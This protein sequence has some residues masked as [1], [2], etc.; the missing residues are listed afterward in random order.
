MTR[1]RKNINDFLDKIHLGDCIDI[2]SEIPDESVDMAFADP[3][4]NLKKNYGNYNDD[5]EDYEY[6]D[7][8]KSWI[9][10]LIRI[11][12]PSGTLFLHNIPKWLIEYGH[13]LNKKNMI[14]KHWIAWDAMSTPLG[15]TLLPNHYGILYY[16]KSENYKFY[17]L[18]KPHD[19]CRVCGE[20]QKDYGGKKVQMHPFGPLL[21]DVWTDIHRI[22]H[23]KRRDDH[24]NQLPEQLLERLILMVTDKGDIVVDPVVGVGTTAIAAKRQGRRFIGID[25]EKTY[26][27]I[28]R[29]KIEDVH[30]DQ[31]NGYFYNYNKKGQQKKSSNLKF[32]ENHTLR[33][34]DIIVEK[35]D[36]E[37][38]ISSQYIEYNIET[39]NKNKTKNK[40][41]ED[42]EQV[43]PVG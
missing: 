35:G 40:E 2:L 8:C 9:D 15:D 17:D 22:R 1:N 43:H 13:Y 39:I 11:L 10:G 24:P 29:K 36:L 16:T 18:R 28:A 42:L 30:K 12:N 6:L 34:E 21:S 14:F 26:V 31:Y 37:A 3:P 7:W 4:F 33:D 32:L 25:N 19:R 41:D 20:V 5:K 38:A 27:D 23:K